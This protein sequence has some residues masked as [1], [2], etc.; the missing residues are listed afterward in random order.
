MAES[1]LQS[2]PGFNPAPDPKLEWALNRSIME[3]SS[4]SVMDYLIGGIFIQAFVIELL[5]DNQYTNL[6]IGLLAGIPPFISLLQLFTPPLLRQFGGKRK[7]LTLTCYSSAR[8]LWIIP[9]LIPFIPFLIAHQIF[10]MWILIIMMCLFTGL[11]AIGGIS[12]SSWISDLVPRERYGRYFAKRSTII[13]VVGTIAALA[14]SMLYD[15][16]KHKYADKPPLDGFSL[17]F[18]IGLIFG[19]ISLYLLKGIQEPQWQ[20]SRPQDTPWKKMLVPL[21][22]KN[23]R[24]FALIQMFWIFALMFS[25]PYFSAYM[26]KNLKLDLTVISIITFVG[27]GVVLVCSPLWGKFCDQFGNRPILMASYVVK[28]F[29][30]FAWLF[31]TSD[32]YWITLMITRVFFCFDLAMSFSAANILYK[33]SPKGDNTGHLAVNGVLVTISSM[34]APIIAGWLTVFAKADMFTVGSFQ[35]ES[36]KLIFLIG[37]ILRVMAMPMLFLVHE[38]KTE[39]LFNAR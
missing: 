35:I 30:C 10:T 25:S 6:Y 18:F 24:R 32:N 5:G 37:G 36:L 20:T 3:G 13:K 19:L 2:N 39:K 22:D 38:P 33:I 16:W 21:K 11:N 7:E 17:I 27:T 1:N 23:F 28:G 34:L 26:R 12:W 14:G 31:V 29:Y 15:S 4:F 9:I 8:I